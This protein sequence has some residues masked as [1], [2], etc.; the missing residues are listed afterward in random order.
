ME[1]Y[2]VSARKYRP[3]TFDS[4][5]GQRALTTTLKNAIASGKLAHAYLF[6]GPR[7]VGKTT[8]ARIF[9]RTINCLTPTE[10]GEACGN[11]ESCKA[12]EQQR[13]FNIHELDAASN[14]SVE[15]IRSLIEQV[16]MPPQVGRYKV[17]IIDEVHMLSTAAFN[18]FL[19]TL[20]EPPAHAIFILATTEKHKIL[21]TILSRCQ[22][23]D[24]NRMEVADIVGHLKHVAQ[25]EGYDYEEEALS[26]IARKADG[27]MR[28]ALSI[29]DQVAGYA[30]GHLTY[31]KVIEDLN[32]LDYDYYFKIVDQMLGK[33]IPAVMLT[34]NEILSKGFAAN[35]FI[36]GFASHLRDLLVSR[37]AQTLPLLEVSETV[38]TRYSE[39]AAKC[40]PQF[41]Y[42]AL[43]FCNDCDLNYRTSSNKRLLVELTLIQVAQAVDDDEAGCGLGPTKILKPLFAAIA[44]AAAAPQAPKAQPAATTQQRPAAT[45]AAATAPSAT[46]PVANTQ[47]TAA[48]QHHVRPVSLSISATKMQQRRKQANSANLDQAR[49]IV[50][51]EVQ[52]FEWKDLSYQWYRFAMELPQEQNAIAG[53][54]K[55]MRPQLMDNFV[56]EVPVENDQVLMLMN[57]IR[58]DLLC[59]LR[60]GLHNGKVDVRFRIIQ[61]E[62]AKKRA[63][64]RQEQLAAML[65][66]SPGLTVLKNTL[67]LE[68]A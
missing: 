28:D 21:P 4:V 31:R 45:P 17:F 38:R 50:I 54:M 37:D 63:Y 55:N 42:R 67:N 7:G 1:N 14:N 16:R 41:L 10:T 19:K 25:Q 6:C 59:Y 32:V 18:A 11:C 57:S 2:I 5:V 61:A 34:L 30:E 15:D 13:S 51:N 47:N 39:Q 23:Y 48:A 36:S 22:I 12:F 62:E 33:D 20:E 8:C 66:K 58:D 52:P 3:L 43:R 24:F 49:R 29:F 44:P 68:L 40:R 53:R 26:V 64:T 65:E 35:H 60:M 56:V 27:G 9:A 46:L